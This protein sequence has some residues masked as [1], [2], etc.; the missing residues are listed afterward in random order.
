MHAYDDKVVPECYRKGPS[1]LGQPGH[2]E[3]LC[4]LGSR[5]EEIGCLHD[6]VQGHY[7]DQP[8]VCQLA[9]DMAKVRV[10]VEASARS[11]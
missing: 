5:S 10:D 2:D 3:R 1:A 6:E 11:Q 9:K 8:W 7:H 4:K